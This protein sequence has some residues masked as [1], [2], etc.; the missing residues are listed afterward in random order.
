MERTCTALYKCACRRTERRSPDR[1]YDCAA[2]EC[3]AHVPLWILYDVMNIQLIPE[4]ALV[5]LLDNNRKYKSLL[6]EKIER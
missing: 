5:T 1:L 4:S 3:G 2:L 6:F